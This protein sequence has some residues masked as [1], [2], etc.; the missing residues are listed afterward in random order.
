MSENPV[1]NISFAKAIEKRP[2]I[3][4]YS[5]TEYSKRNLTEKAWVEVAN[6][7]KIQCQIVANA[8]ETSGEHFCDL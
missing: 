4:N 3:W 6:E 7:I 2:C 8:G 1:F 5:L